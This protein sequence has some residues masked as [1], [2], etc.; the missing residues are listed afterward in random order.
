MTRNVIENSGNEIVNLLNRKENRVNK[1]FW[2]NVQK[3]N[4]WDE[5]PEWFTK[6][7]MKKIWDDRFEGLYTDMYLIWNSF[8]HTLFIVGKHN[9]DWRYIS[10]FGIAY[11]N[12]EEMPYE[13][14]SDELGI[15]K[16]GITI[17]QL[18]NT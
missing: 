2:L 14:M 1:K 3:I 15:D 9:E 12:T 5:L 10:L 8:R 4:G 18:L 6:S 17:E 11:S 13:Q 16:Y 7:A